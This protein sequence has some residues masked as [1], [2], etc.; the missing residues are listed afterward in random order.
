MQKHVNAVKTAG[1]EYWW[2]FIQLDVYFP[3]KIDNLF[4][5]IHVL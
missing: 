3:S 4:I 1:C 2:I 5:A